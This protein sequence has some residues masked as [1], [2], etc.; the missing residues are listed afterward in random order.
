MP[1]H[2]P[3]L[4]YAHSWLRQVGVRLSPIRS[5]ELREAS[6]HRVNTPHGPLQLLVLDRGDSVQGEHAHGR[7]YEPE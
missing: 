1:W 6:L 4:N 7:L 2:R 5:S 3:L